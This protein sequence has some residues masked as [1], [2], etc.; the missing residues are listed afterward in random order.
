MEN[1][2]DDTMSLVPSILGG[3]KAQKTHG[4]QKFKSSKDTDQISLKNPIVL[5]C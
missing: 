1:K 3:E 5:H 2:I 4:M